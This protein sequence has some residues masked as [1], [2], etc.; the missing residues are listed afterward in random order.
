MTSVQLVIRILPELPA[1]A[2]YRCVFGNSTPI[3]ATVLENGLSCQ[4][5]PVNN[6]PNIPALSDHVSVPLSVRS[7]ETNKDFVSRSFSFFDCSRHDT[8]RK[9]VQSEWNC[10]WCLYDNRCVH[11]STTCRNT[12]SVISQSAVCNFQFRDSVLC[13]FL[14]RF[15]FDNFSVCFPYSEFHQIV[16]ST[17]QANCKQ[18][19]HFIGKPSAKRN[20]LGNREFTTSA[21]CAHRL[22]V[23]CEYWRR[24]HVA[25]RTCWIEKVYR[26]WENY[27]LVWGGHQW[28]RS[29]RWH[30]V[31]SKSLHR[32]RSNYSVQVWCPRIASWA[33]RLFIVCNTAL[34]IPVHM[35]RHHMHVQRNV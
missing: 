8:C 2:K 34:K 4:T 28:I 1:N 11:N 25:A 3:D 35:V 17:L 16:M 15:S 21:K 27:L 24:T 12:A 19:A 22:L 7:S 31:E 9:C 32:H 13:N 10:N 14:C 5:P 30:F 29:T 18:W 20:T 6:R 33:C 23:H 26:L